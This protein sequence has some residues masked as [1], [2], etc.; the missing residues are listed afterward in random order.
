MNLSLNI[1]LDQLR[2]LPLEVHIDDPAEKIFCRGA[3][4]PRDYRVMRK[5]LLH[6]CR[7]SDAL[8]ASSAVPDRFYLCIRDRI[9]DGQETDERLQG[10]IIVNEN[11]ETEL[12]LNTVQEI[13]DRISEWYRKMQDALIHEAGLQTILEL[14][15]PIIGNTINISDSAFTLL[16]RTTHIETDDPHEPGP[17]G[18]WLSPGVHLAAVSAESSV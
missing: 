1:I 8:R 14:S 5:D 18:V 16:A 7:L 12:L 13:F 11:M 17:G 10:M 9:T 3:L 6:V 15:E 2:S 4:L